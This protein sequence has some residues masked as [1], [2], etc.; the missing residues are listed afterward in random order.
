MA[1]TQEAAEMAAGENV[2]VIATPSE[3]HVVVARLDKLS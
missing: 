3:G 1:E 2:L